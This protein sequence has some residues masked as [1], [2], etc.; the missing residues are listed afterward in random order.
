MFILKPIFGKV[1]GCQKLILN[2]LME[3]SQ[4]KKYFKLLTL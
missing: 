4:N 3:H 2:T 1:S